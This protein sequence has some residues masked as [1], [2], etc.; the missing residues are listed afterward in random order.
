MLVSQNGYY[1]QSYLLF[2]PFDTEWGHLHGGEPCQRHRSDQKTWVLPPT[3]ISKWTSYPASHQHVLDPLT[4]KLKF[5]PSPGHHKPSK[6]SVTQPHSF[7]A[8]LGP[9]LLSVKQGNPS[10]SW[11]FHFSR[12]G[13]VPSVG[14]GT[15]QE[16]RNISCFSMSLSIPHASWCHLRINSASLFFTLASF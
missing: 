3:N 6:S 12:H 7:T 11:C 8:S 16:L 14:C 5:P 15:W 9:V 10:Q 1:Q 2:K 13:K 4:Q